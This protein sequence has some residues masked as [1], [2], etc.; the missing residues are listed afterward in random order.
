MTNQDYQLEE[1]ENAA[2]K[3]S[4]TAKRVA[5][6]AGL[7]AAGGATG[8]GAT[9]LANNLSEETPMETLSE[10]DLDSVVNAGANQVPEPEPEPEPEPQ[11]A[12]Q[13]TPARNATPHKIQ[14]DDVDISFDK[15]THFYDSDNDLMMTTEEGRVD[16]YDF[17]LVD[18]DG[19]LR[20]D[21]IG[22]DANGD[23]IYSDDEI[24][25]LQGEDQIA[26]GNSTRYH[27]DV[28]V[29]T[30]PEPEPY[31][32]EDEKDY[33]DVAR[34]DYSDEK[35]GESYT[36]DLGQSTENYDDNL[37]YDGEYKDED[38]YDYGLAQ[39]DNHDDTYDDLGSDSFDLG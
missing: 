14:N 18:V 17:K 4:N 30:N 19:D 11:H 37:A 6:A 23:G 7:L 35:D 36:P 2:V 38:D 3:K 31:V 13:A 33:V 12:R 20:A 22:I 34:H 1:L 10:E 27:E 24:V 28:F 29:D 39:N 5:A 26:M 21:Y 8:F 16:G 15:T 9:T 25:S 32:L